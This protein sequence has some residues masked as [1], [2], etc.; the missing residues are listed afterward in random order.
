[1]FNTLYYIIIIGYL[2]NSFVVFEGIMNLYRISQDHHHPVPPAYQHLREERQSL[3]ELYEGRLFQ[4]SDSL[5]KKQL[6]VER[7]ILEIEEKLAAATPS[8][9]SQLNNELKQLHSL[10]VQLFEEHRDIEK[11]LIGRISSAWRYITTTSKKFT[12]SGLT[13]ADFN[14]RLQRVYHL[15]IVNVGEGDTILLMRAGKELSFADLV[16]L[17]EKKVERD[18]RHHKD[19]SDAEVL[20]E[21]LREQIPK[22]TQHVSLKRY[23]GKI[24]SAPFTSGKTAEHSEL[25]QKILTHQAFKVMQESGHY[26]GT[27]ESRVSIKEGEKQEQ[28]QRLKM[29]VRTT[30]D[31]NELRIGKVNRTTTGKTTV[32]VLTSDGRQLS[33]A[34]LFEKTVAKV[35]E[36][37]KKIKD[38][39]NTNVDVEEVRKLH[40]K[41]VRAE[42]LVELLLDKNVVEYLS[43]KR[44]ILFGILKGVSQLSHA[45]DYLKDLPGKIHESWAGSYS[46]KNVL[47]AR[48]EIASKE[49]VQALEKKTSE[50]M[51]LLPKAPGAFEK[52]INEL[53][54]NDPTGQHRL[55]IKDLFTHKHRALKNALSLGNIRAA[56]FLIQHGMYDKV[57]DGLLTAVAKTPRLSLDARMLLIKDLF[58]HTEDHDSLTNIIAYLTHTGESS[59][60]EKLILD[61]LVKDRDVF[62]AAVQGKQK[63]SSKQI[64]CLHLAAQVGTP[65]LLKEAFGIIE[66]TSLPDIV[67][68]L[69]PFVLLPDPR[70]ESLLAYACMGHNAKFVTAINL[71]I[72]ELYLEVK[73]PQKEI[74]ELANTIEKYE[75]QDMPRGVI[76]AM[77]VKLQELRNEKMRKNYREQK[78]EVLTELLKYHPSK[79][80]TIRAYIE[81]KIANQFPEL[82]YLQEAY[83]D[84]PKE[85]SAHLKRELENLDVDP[86]LARNAEYVRPLQAMS[87]GLAADMDA[88]LHAHAQPLASGEKP[89]V[90]CFAA[91]A[92]YYAAERTKTLLAAEAMGVITQA[93][94]W[95]LYFAK[96]MP[97]LPIP[98]LGKTDTIKSS[99]T[100]IEISYGVL[101]GGLAA[102]WTIKKVA[103]YDALHSLEG[104][105]RNIDQ[106]RAA[107]PLDKEF[108]EGLITVPPPKAASGF[109]S[110]F[111]PLRNSSR[112]EEVIAVKMKQQDVMEVIHL[113]E[114]VKGE[115][116]D[117]KRILQGYEKLYRYPDDT[118]YHVFERLFDVLV[119][120]EHLNEAVDI[121]LNAG[122][123]GRQCVKDFFDHKAEE[124]KHKHPHQIEYE[125]AIFTAAKLGDAELLRK[126]LDIK[127]AAAEFAAAGR[128]RNAGGDETTLLHTAI[129]SK[130]PGSSRNKAAVVRILYEESIKA[131]RIDIDVEPHRTKKK[132]D[133]LTESRMGLTPLDILSDTE[134]SALDKEFK[135]SPH[136]P[137]SFTHALSM[138]A[139]DY[140][141]DSTGQLLISMAPQTILGSFAPPLA[142]I[143]AFTAAVAAAKYGPV[144]MC[145]A[146]MAAR[147]LVL[148]VFALFGATTGSYF[149]EA[150][151]NTLHQ[152]ENEVY[153][154]SASVTQLGVTQEERERILKL[155][156]GGSLQMIQIDKETD[157]MIRQYTLEGLE[158][159]LSAADANGDFLSVSD[160][161][162]MKAAVEALP[163]DVPYKEL[164][165]TVHYA[166]LRANLPVSLRIIITA[167]I[168]DAFGTVAIV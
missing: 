157:V 24:F 131:R 81:N 166:M 16:I 91:A 57:P 32:E 44:E 111:N 30:F 161:K 50:I 158:N 62:A 98:I 116:V 31:H 28:S 163:V 11:T 160:L 129:S 65:A 147:V 121:Q 19:T 103:D 118:R 100:F 23:I 7:G 53:L 6:A 101:F 162:A 79:T 66:S 38:A 71:A 168:G 87:F 35:Q 22:I 84:K 45:I 41:L 51:K 64:A 105:N 70:G 152:L 29:L 97:A 102:S 52:A 99:K 60:A 117:G 123:Q 122:I 20:L 43:R 110:N 61:S 4:K 156:E 46:F 83:K 133:P 26:L 126:L 85:L 90:E 106:F 138:R 73:V 72:K 42:E 56:H 140:S 69:K 119:K 8:E 80:A 153:S 12:S 165:E 27:S 159:A 128:W 40:R 47:A 125:A 74:Q 1:M 37:Q 112:H 10:R 86:F 59:F 77:K 88:L 49:E 55:I 54:E 151:T 149:G 2:T 144:A 127:L 145:L 68:A 96:I 63:F 135:L 143:L 104:S 36:I 82:D 15:E 124:W 25:A 18:K 150:F 120:V 17:T 109:L 89:R 141:G 3:H 136:Q 114:K 154:T 13:I 108:P 94:S 92:A 48:G 137:G 107:Y 5:H 58:D 167:K 34:E 93:L 142:N 164:V 21:Y 75:S 78:R 115:N 130:V 76:E 67:N 132:R 139:E 9:K 146:D 95:A 155:R 33:K 14:E 148:K 134:A 39:H 113:L